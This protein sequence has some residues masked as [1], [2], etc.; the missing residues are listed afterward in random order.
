MDS[1]GPNAITSP[2]R[3]RPAMT[4]G[5]LSRMKKRRQRNRVLYHEAVALAADLGVETGER[6]SSIPDIL[7]KVF[8]RTHALW[9]TIATAVDNLDADAKPGAPNSLWHKALDEQGN[10]IYSPAKEVQLEQTLREELFDQGVRL[11]QLNIDS[12]AVRVEEVKLELLAR[13]LDN[14]VKQVG[15]PEKQRKELGAA[16]RS[17]LHVL[18]GTAE[19]VPAPTP[20]ADSRLSKAS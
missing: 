20:A 14:A 3:R 15:L 2:N 7:M 12:R 9:L 11:S 19:E 1:K 16:L 4:K 5:Q 13:A 18:E 6:V 8:E 10:W 17:E